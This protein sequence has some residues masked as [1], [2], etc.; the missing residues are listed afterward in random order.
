MHEHHHHAQHVKGVD[1]QLAIRICALLLLRRSRLAGLGGPHL[2]GL[3]NEGVHV[4]HDRMQLKA[5]HE[6]LILEDGRIALFAHVS[7]DITQRCLASKM[8]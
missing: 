3:A 6:A 4:G 8:F 1:E 7:A 2:V 5:I